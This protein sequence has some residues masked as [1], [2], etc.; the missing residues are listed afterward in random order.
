MTGGYTDHYTNGDL[1][2][3]MKIFLIYNG[4]LNIFEFRNQLFLNSVVVRYVV[5]KDCKMLT[6][7]GLDRIR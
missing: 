2:V 1:Y 3:P 6:F 7:I 5:Q 4:L